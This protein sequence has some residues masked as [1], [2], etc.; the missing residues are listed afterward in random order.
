[1]GDAGGG[2]VTTTLPATAFS[3]G[4]YTLPV[5]PSVYQANPQWFVTPTAAGGPLRIPVPAG[6]PVLAVTTG[7][8]VSVTPE[9]GGVRLVLAGSDGA[10]YL[11]GGVVAPR[12]RPGQQVKPGSRLSEAGAAGLTLEITVPDVASPVCV[13]PALAAWAAG[14]TV[15]MHALPTAGCGSAVAAAKGERVAVVADPPTAGVANQISQLLAAEGLKPQMVA[16]ATPLADVPPAQWAAAI[17]PAVIKAKAPLAVVVAGLSQPTP[18]TV[19]LTAGVSAVAAGLPAGVRVSWAQ[20]VATPPTG[21]MAVPTDPALAAV[22]AAHPALR[23]QSVQPLTVSPGGPLATGA[24]ADQA[25][26]GEVVDYVDSAWGLLGADR[27]DWAAAFATRIGATN[28]AAVE[29]VQAWTVEEGAS[30]WANNPLNSSLKVK[31]SSPLAGNPDGVQTYP[32]VLTGLNADV[33]TLLTNPAYAPVVAALRAGQVPQAAAA[34]QASPWC[35]G[36]GGGQCPGY[37]STIAGM[38]R[39]WQQAAPEALAVSDQPVG[40]VLTSVSTSAGAPADFGPVWQFLQAQLGK[41]YLWGGAGPNA[42]D[43][44]GLV[45]AAYAQAGLHFVHFA[46]SQYAATASHP[47][48]LSSLEPGDLLFWTTIPGD[49]AAIEHVAVYVGNGMVL[50]APHTGTDVQIQPLWTNGLYGATR[51][52]AE[53]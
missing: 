2:S 48:P 35:Q 42:W 1:M 53:G 44:S 36:S 23:V 17:D 9:A 41:P 37:G 51:P 24:R 28:P 52:L 25:N 29:F 32:S 50:D 6:T 39:F 38:V 49:A 43:C 12:V 14:S 5:A 46:A 13:Q 3:G 33:Q 15:D 30:A 16:L 11:Y 21:T 26:A 40:S 45:M 20:P 22:I 18:A 27:Q 47:V 19:N 31:G 8:V 34:L 4:L 7:M 10:T